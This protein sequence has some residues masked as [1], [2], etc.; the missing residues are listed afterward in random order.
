M[1]FA[2]EYFVANRSFEMGD[3]AAD[4]AGSLIGY[5]LTKR[6]QKNKPL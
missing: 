6:A 3:I 5:F 2:Q 4:A 1:E